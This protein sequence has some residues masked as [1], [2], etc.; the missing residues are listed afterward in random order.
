MDK[1]EELAL[2]LNDDNASRVCHEGLNAAASEVISLTLI[3]INSLKL[4]FI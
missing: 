3:H 4:D 2:K 1:K